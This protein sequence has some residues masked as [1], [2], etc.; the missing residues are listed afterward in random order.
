MAFSNELFDILLGVILIFA[1]YFVNAW[2]DLR[3]LPK[4]SAARREALNGNWQ[5]FFNQDTV[6]NHPAKKIPIKVRI[7]AG[8]RVV[9]GEMRVT[10]SNMEFEFRFKGSFH[11]DEYLRL[12]YD[13]TGKTQHAKDFGVVFMRLNDLANGLNGKINGYGSIAETLISGS[14]SLEKYPS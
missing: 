2:L 9:K 6:N 10:D 13:A 5:G 4:I 8:R 14:V 7:A 3:S 11:G 12:D 1:G